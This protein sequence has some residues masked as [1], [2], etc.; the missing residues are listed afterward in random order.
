[1]KSD[2]EAVVLIVGFL[3]YSSN[4]KSDIE[5]VVL[6]VMSRS[7]T[8]SLSSIFES[9]YDLWVIPDFISYSIYRRS[10]NLLALNFILFVSAHL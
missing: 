3:N 9:L 4:M 8:C 1:M 6:I 2:I 10:S 5:A 7:L